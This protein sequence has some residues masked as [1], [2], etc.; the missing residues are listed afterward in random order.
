MDDEPGDAGAEGGG[1]RARGPRL[2]VVGTPIGNLGDLSPRA[3]RAL[4]DADLVLAEDTR[5]TG[6]LLSRL[7]IEARLRSSHEHNEHARRDEVVARVAGGDVVAL[8]SDAGMPVV[9]DPGQAIVAAVVAAGLPVEVV[10]GPSAPSAALAVSGLPAARWC[11]EGFLPRRGRARRSRLAALA[12]EERTLVFFVAPH[13]AGE[14]LRDLATALGHDRPAAVCRELTKLHEEVVRGPLG[15]LAARDGA[16]RGEITLVVQ[17]APPPET[18]EVEDATLAEEV[19]A[20][21]ADGHRRRAAAD[22]VATRHGVSRR[23]AY[24]ASLHTED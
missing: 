10:P 12:T 8:V 2:V 3:V 19:A 23:R 6:R 18:V 24:E 15:D 21:M 14:D 13:H 22:E 9:S 1:D 5:H 7:G 4:R 11:F 20:A 17:G 16:W